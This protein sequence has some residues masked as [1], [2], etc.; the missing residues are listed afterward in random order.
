MSEEERKERHQVNYT[1]VTKHTAQDWADTFIT[2]LNDTHIE[3]DLRD[4]QA[5]PQVSLCQLKKESKK[6]KDGRVNQNTT[7]QNWGT[8]SG[9]VK[10][11][12]EE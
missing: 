12:M 9:G 4:R 10:L 11:G 6:A 1:H 7:Y 8:R 5:P 3:A 2:E